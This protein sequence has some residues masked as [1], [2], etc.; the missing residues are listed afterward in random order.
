MK[1]RIFL[2]VLSMTL[3]LLMMTMSVAAETTDVP[4]ELQTSPVEE[5][6]V[7]YNSA[8][9]ETYTNDFDTVKSVVPE[10]SISDNLDYY[11]GNI[12]ES[13][14]EQVKT[15][16]GD[17]NNPPVAALQVVVLNPES[18]IN[19]NFTTETQLAWLWAYNGQSFTYD[20]DGDEI[21]DIRIGGISSSD[22]IGTITG[23][24]G[25]AT[26]CK[27]PAQYILTFQ[28][29]DSKGEWSNVAEYAFQIEP[30][31]GNSRPICNVGTSSRDLVA[32]QLMLISW[33]DSYDNDT[34]DSVSGA[35]G[36]VI[37]DGSMTTIEDYAEEVG[38]D[39][40]ILSFDK[41]G[42][43]EIRM[44]VSD[45]HGAWSNWVVFNAVVGDA[46]LNNVTVKGITDLSSS[47]AYWVDQT[48]AKA[49]N[50]SCSAEG[51][52][53]LCDNFG[54]HDVPPGY[55]DKIVMGESFA[56]SGQVVSED[57]TPAANVA[58]NIRMPVRDSQ[59]LNKT[60]YTDSNG[61]FRYEPEPKQYWVDTKFYQNVNE[62]NLL[63]VGTRNS[64]YIRYSP[65]TGTNFVNST[66]VKVS[67]GGDSYSE[68][69][70]CEIG[71]SKN[72]II[73]NFVYY[74]GEWYYI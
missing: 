57:G 9:D 54:T 36:I 64:S 66:T 5:E 18:M 19:G 63:S 16:S 24:L 34:G 11:K 12:E 74:K 28:V 67:S 71:Y 42:T 32:D 1:K 13:N 30:A 46:S 55:P 2:G 70:I 4:E 39:Y 37:K 33:A 56:V 6:S 17:E 43:Y 31:D 47:K 22:I 23:N 38:T 29:Q 69:V 10:L 27:T 62:V 25:F 20:P 35:N 68:K 45:S 72:P 8:L 40:C 50:V 41:A 65:S 51:V 44:R 7:F 48:A 52:Q 26:Q 15:L 49:C 73:G 60:V 61:E 14:V 59:T 3:L 53:Y 21:T 58:V